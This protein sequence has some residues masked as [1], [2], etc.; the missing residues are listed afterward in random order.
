MTQGGA[1]MANPL[2]VLVLLGLV[3]GLA[4]YWWLKPR[5]GKG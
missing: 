2:Q 1:P 5:P 4:A 3:L